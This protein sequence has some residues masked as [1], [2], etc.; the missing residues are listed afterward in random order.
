MKT[1]AVIMAG[2]KGERFWPRSR[3]DM[4]KQFLSLTSDGKTMIQHTIDRILPLVNT[5]DIFIVTN[6]NYKNLV[7]EQL[8]D[9]KEKNVILE[10]ASRNT[11]PCIGL[12][13]TYI[14]QRYKDEETVMVVLPSD[15]LIKYNE[16]FIDTLKSAIEIAKEDKNMVTIGITPSYPETGYG[17]INFGYK[18]NDKK[19]NGAYKV[20]KFVEKPDLDKAKEYLASGKYLWNSGMF[21]WKTSTILNS[22]EVYLPEIYQ[23]LARIGNCIGTNMEVETL[24]EEFINFKSESIDYGIMEKYEPIYTVP[25]SFGWDDIGSWLALERTYQSDDEGNIVDG[26]VITIG[27][28][29]S[30]IQARNKLV[31]TVG[32][33]DIIIVDTEDAIL[34][35]DKNNVQDVKKVIENLKVCNRNQYL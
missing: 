6:K 15:H 26:N 14:R 8:P 30:I 24:K 4:P 29:N 9:I 25:G 33:K 23:G 11:A 22:F 35:C 20:N 17:Y 16:I 21:V 34:I 3:K 27:V 7:L 12:V 28:K 13:A 5:E 1:V 19:Y 10:P 18:D 2:G 32:V 31:A